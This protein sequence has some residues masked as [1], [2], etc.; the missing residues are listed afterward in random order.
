MRK[1]SAQSYRHLL[2]L[3]ATL[4][5]VNQAI[6]R[7]SDEDALYRKICHIATEFGHFRFVWIGVADPARQELLPVAWSGDGARYLREI[8]IFLH[9]DKPEGRG[10]A[11]RA[12]HTGKMQVVHDFFNDLRT[13][14]WVAAARRH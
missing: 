5:Q 3:Y 6:L 14:P 9:P 7:V 2:S 1:K 8:R 13:A 4:S 11:A 12:F 10:P